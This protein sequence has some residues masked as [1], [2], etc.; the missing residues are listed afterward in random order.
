MQCAFLSAKIIYSIQLPQSV[1]EIQHLRNF[2]IFMYYNFHVLYI[3]R[4]ENLGFPM[5]R[6]SATFRDKGT[7]LPSLSRDIGT[8]GEAKNISKGRDSQNLGRD[9]TEQKRM[10]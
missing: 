1:D 8:T 6:D 5:G 7:E 10:F 3:I 2:K 4:L 9:R